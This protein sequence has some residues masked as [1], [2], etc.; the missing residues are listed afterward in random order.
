M[1]GPKLLLMTALAAVAATASYV[2]LAAQEPHFSQHARRQGNGTNFHG[3]Y[4]T[5]GRD[6]V[7]ARGE[8]VTWAGVNWPMS[9]M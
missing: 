5:K 4:S 8:K 7:D 9:G 2:P 3:P 6:V 1:L